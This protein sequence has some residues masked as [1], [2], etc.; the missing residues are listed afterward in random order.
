MVYIGDKVNPNSVYKILG[1]FKYYIE[2]YIFS[3]LSETQGR[4][5]LIPWIWNIS[6][7]RWHVG[8]QGEKTRHNIVW[9][10]QIANSRL[11]WQMNTKSRLK[12]LKMVALLT[13]RTTIL[14]AWWILA[15]DDVIVRH[16]RPH[17]GGENGI[18]WKE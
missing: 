11:R 2:T 3:T 12:D 6:F 9:T 17:L 7:W 8:V 5:L 18:E 1:P 14:M 16:V 15:K 13:K 10:V 4:I